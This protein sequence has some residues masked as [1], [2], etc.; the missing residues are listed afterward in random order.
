MAM[1]EGFS[2]TQ[3]FAPAVDVRIVVCVF[4]AF[5]ASLVHTG[6]EFVTLEQAT[7]D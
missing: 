4:G 1:N 6:Q 2:P 7:L 5:Q 3:D